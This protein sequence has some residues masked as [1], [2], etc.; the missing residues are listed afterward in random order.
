[1]TFKMYDGVTVTD[2]PVEAV[3]VP[4]YIDGKYANI[5]PVQQRFPNAVIPTITTRGDLDANIADSEEGDLTPAQLAEWCAEKV[6]ENKGHPTGYC[7]KD[8]WQTCKD[9]CS[10]LGVRPSWWIAD[11]TGELHILHGAVAV[12]CINEAKLGYDVSLVRN[13]WPGVMAPMPLRHRVAARLVING[14]S[15]R[16]VQM[17]PN[18]RHIATSLNHQSARVLHL[19]H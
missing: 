2:I 14:W 6:H 3:I 12:Q 15:N 18:Q 13:A 11:W 8:K 5:L 16:N 4:G 9:E 7:S 17:I 19:G 1:M 10:K